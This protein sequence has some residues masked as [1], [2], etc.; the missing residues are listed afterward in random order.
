MKQKS[1]H[2]I[3]TVRAALTML[4]IMFIDITLSANN[5]ELLKEAEKSY[6]K[7]EFK[8]A[9]ENY[10]KLVSS[11]Q[12]SSDLYFNLG[13]SYF[14]NNQIGKAI[15]NYELAHK[16][17]P[18]NEDI[19]HNLIIANKRKRDDFETKENYFAK[20]IESGIVNMF[21]NSG[22]AWMTIICMIFSLL[23]FVGY[24]LSASIKFRKL[25]FWLGI[26]GLLK[27]TASFFIG[28]QSLQQLTEKTN[29]I[30]LSPEVYVLNAPNSTGKT[31]FTLH[32]GT[33]VKI[34]NSNNS[35]TSIILENGNEGWLPTKDIAAY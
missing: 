4:L 5:T 34:L 18:S 1:N 7:G 35:W 27:F 9:V 20:N 13:N 6:E 16:I 21:T 23:C 3:I 32:E 33:K 24:K 22:W 30:V 14:K 25:L 12:L 8:K 2:K 31:Q 19:K 10:E 15:Y 26:I 28:F 11:G 17:N 29:A